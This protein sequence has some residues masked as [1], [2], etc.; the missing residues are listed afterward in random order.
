MP[1]PPEPI[2]SDDFLFMETVS[3]GAY[4]HKRLNDQNGWAVLAEIF[5][6]QLVELQKLD[7]LNKMLPKDDM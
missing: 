1:S 7:F 2:A 6:D 4:T 3:S 5:A